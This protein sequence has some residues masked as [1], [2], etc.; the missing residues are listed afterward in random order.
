[1]W[2]CFKKIVKETNGIGEKLQPFIMCAKCEH[3]FNYSKGAS[4]FNLKKH[5]CSKDIG[6]PENFTS[7]STDADVSNRKKAS[8]NV[9][10]GIK[11]DVTDNCV[12]YVMQDLRSFAAV[13]DGGFKNL[14]RC[15]VETGMKLASKNFRYK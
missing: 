2:V 6:E 14:A 15:F 9:T 7:I 1:M 4:S 12:Q 3:I 10:D 13:N 8:I 5:R 11:K